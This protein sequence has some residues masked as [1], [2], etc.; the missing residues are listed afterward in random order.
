MILNKGLRMATNLQ[1]FSLSL[2]VRDIWGRA[3]EEL[4]GY[5]RIPFE[6]NKVFADPVNPT[7]SAWYLDRQID[8]SIQYGVPIVWM[9]QACPDDNA[10]WRTLAGH[11]GSPL[12]NADSGAYPADLRFRRP[13]PALYPAIKD[14]IE[15]FIERA[16]ARLIAADKNPGEWMAVQW[17]NEPWI[18]VAGEPELFNGMSNEMVPYLKGLLDP[19]EIELWSPPLGG[20][21]GAT[22]TFEAQI[23]AELE[24]F[25]IETSNDIFVNSAAPNGPAHWEHYDAITCHSP[26]IGIRSYPQPDPATIA[27]LSAEKTYKSQNLVESRFAALGLPTGRPWHATEGGMGYDYFGVGSLGRV[28]DDQKRGRVIR[29]Q[30]EN[31]LN[32]VETFCTYVLANANSS[33][34]YPNT[35]EQAQWGLI[36]AGG[37]HTKAMLEVG[38]TSGR[39][40][41]EPIDGDWAADA[42]G[43]ELITGDQ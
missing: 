37:T 23:A 4:M 13:E 34:D 15:Q 7:W 19:F 36:Q 14:C 41:I 39:A 22:L 9:I 28:M 33:L 5:V 35:T 3:C 27:R 25:T 26:Y 40:S 10:T 16:T 38:R 1:D 8:W 12:L 6:F 32:Y 21:V 24:R 29:L 31:C 43:S 18:A 2:A 17:W 42:Y 30:V 11:A 20:G